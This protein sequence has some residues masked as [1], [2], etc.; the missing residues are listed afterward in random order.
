MD[1]QLADLD[2]QF[3][4]AIDDVGTRFGGLPP[5]E[6]RR[7]AEPQAWSVAEC[8]AHLT[9]T[10]RAFL[11]L[12]DDAIARAPARAD[13]S[14]F[15][16]S[17]LGGWLARNMEPPVRGRYKTIAGFIPVV[18]ESDGDVIMNFAR[19]QEELRARLQSSDGR[20]LSKVRVRS[21]FNRYLTYNVYTAFLILAAHQRRHIWQADEVRKRLARAG[22]R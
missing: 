21:A 2:R 22:L 18:A 3:A 16:K 4:S 5:V 8:I 6:L 13:Q 10:T 15:K 11:P 19:S 17:F 14:P 7:R 1:P 20:D 9:L 12:L